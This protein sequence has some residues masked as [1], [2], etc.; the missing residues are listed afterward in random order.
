MLLELCVGAAGLVLVI[1]YLLTRK[2]GYWKK[3]N[4]PHLKPV[5][6]F[7]NF[8][9]VMLSKTDFG[10][11]EHEI[12]NQFPDEPLVGA[13]LGPEPI[14][15][16]K[17]PEMVKLVTTK[18]FYYFSPR[19]TAD[20]SQKEWTLKNL[21]DSQGDLW[22]VLRQNLT[23]LFSSAKMKNMFYLIEKCSKT[24]E[25][26]LEKEISISRR[27]EARS[28]FS[29][30]TMDCIGICAFGVDT[31]VMIEGDDNPFMN[32][33]KQIFEATPTQLVKTLFRAISPGLFYGLGLTSTPQSVMN[34]FHTLLVKVFKERGYKHTNRNDFIDLILSFSDKKYIYGD[35]LS[36]MKSEIKEKIKI[37]VDDHLL[38]A[39]CF[40]FFFAGFETSSTTASFTLYELAKD[41]VAQ[42]R[43]RQEV[44]EWLRKRDGRLDYEC[45]SE[46]PFLEQC[47]DEALRLYPVGGVL[48]RAVVEPYRFP[49]GVTVERGLSVHLPIFH[50]HRNPEY[51]PDPD[52]FRP[53][54][55][56]PENKHSIR[57]YTYMP[58]GEGPRICI[59]MRFAKMQVTA[60]LVTILKKYRVELAEDM[61]RTID[62]DPKSFVTAS[63]QGILLNFIP[64]ED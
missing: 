61:P 47:V 42:D 40:V 14:L 38:V 41:Q 4:V 39:Q 33:G 1:Y 49:N 43:A 45:I 7:G 53:E 52:V 55:F 9:D 24:F 18:D 35:R 56:A 25:N 29:R 48:T 15:V 27:Q 32:V 28:L 36:N 26:M 17:D 37:E 12:C 6:L 57:P 11:M 21:F 46:L 20:Y 22:R 54:R 51:Y 59:G 64:L 8:A 19:E 3:K 2:F 31:K 23:P 5:P 63:R 44:R 34:F 58:F 13:Y 30:F 50:L 62:F 10:S 60:G 16:V